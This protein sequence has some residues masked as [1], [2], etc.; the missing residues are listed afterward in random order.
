MCRADAVV[1]IDTLS[2]KK[3]RIIR[4]L[5]VNSQLQLRKYIDSLVCRLNRVCDRH[6]Y[7]KLNAKQA[8]IS[9]PLGASFLIA[10]KTIFK[11][12][13]IVVSLG[14]LAWVLSLAGV[15]DEQ[16]RADFIALLSNAN[17]LFLALS[18][19]IG[20]VVN[21]SSALKWYMLVLA[22]N[23]QVGYWRV[24]SYYLIGQFYNIFLP[25]SVGGD[26]V[27]SYQLGE[28]TKD[29]AASLASVFVERY[30]GILT[31]LVFAAFAAGLQ[32]TVFNVDFV[33]L[34]LVF[35]AL[36]LGVIA[37]S[38]LDPRPYALVK[39][40]I[41]SRTAKLDGILSKL[42]RLINSV[43]DYRN[44]PSALVYAFVN[45]GVFYFLAALNIYL[46]SK[47]FSLDINLMD[48]LVATPIIMLIMNI[49][50]SFGN[51]GLMEF[52]YTSVF[53][54]LGY[55]PALGLSVALLMRGKS[56]LDGALGGVLQAF[57]V[58]RSAN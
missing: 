54:L 20:V 22:K 27:R 5:L 48:A 18:I 51:I 26:V 32:L 2:V 46:S 4:N 29:H 43:N 50:F 12:T 34:S 21:M 28:Y 3:P 58:T 39:R 42:D 13:Q 53:A 33:L 14:L 52:A 16:G 38:V 31:L 49:P 10:K 41:Q 7:A 25:T 8:K 1:M 19:G 36:V 47:V 30:T 17:G 11:L 6:V 44:T 24:F 37:W 9:T 35:F 45:S 40:L 55:D 15:F 56:L 57:F 23:L